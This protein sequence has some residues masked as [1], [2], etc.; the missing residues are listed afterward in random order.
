MAFEKLLGLKINFNKIEI[1]CYGAEN[2]SMSIHK[3]LDVTRDNF[4]LNTLE[5]LC[6]IENLITQSGW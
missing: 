4:L 1:F 6:I 2:D 5:F 3:F